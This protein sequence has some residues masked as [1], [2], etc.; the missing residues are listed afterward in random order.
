MESQNNKELIGNDEANSYGNNER[1]LT[2]DEIQG[3]QLPIDRILPGS[4]L[5]A[6][7]SQVCSLC[8]YALHYIQTE[9]SDSRT[10]VSSF[11]K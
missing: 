5:G 6:Q 8:E 1:L 7:S 2:D 11:F 3:A 10:E 9:L 4:L